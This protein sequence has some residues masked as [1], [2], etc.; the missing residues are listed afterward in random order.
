[1]KYWK[2]LKRE[3]ENIAIIEKISFNVFLTRIE[4]KKS[5]V[6]LD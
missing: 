6:F 5:F 1:M 4:K 2:V 3:A